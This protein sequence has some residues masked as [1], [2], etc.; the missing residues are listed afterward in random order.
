MKRAEIEPLLPDIFERTL[1]PRSPL[2]ALLDIMEAL[3]QPAEEAL[4]HLDACFDARRTADPFVPFLARW[5]DLERLFIEEA[6]VAPA[7]PRIRLST[8]VGRLR[9]LVATAADLSKLRGTAKGLLQFLH[10]ATGERGFEIRENVSSS[11]EPRLYHLTVAAPAVVRP[12]R[13]LIARI[14]ESEKP[15]YVTY[16]LVIAA[17]TED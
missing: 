1:R 12:H 17:P 16:E 9:E 3:H 7:H 11:G 10:A 8:G 5:V 14:I 2:A 13:D 15:A 4:A 6:D